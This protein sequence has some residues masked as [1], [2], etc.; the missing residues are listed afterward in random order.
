MRRIST[1][2]PRSGGDPE[3]DRDREGAR[4][5]QDEIEDLQDAIRFFGGDSAEFRRRLERVLAEFDAIR[6]RYEMTREQLSDAERQNEKL[7]GML[8]E[9]KQQIELLK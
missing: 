3:S 9:A 1:S 2:G 7:V 5:Y 6:R 8:Q 4:S